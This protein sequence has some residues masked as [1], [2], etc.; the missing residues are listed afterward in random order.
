M[1]RL[2]ALGSIALLPVS[3]FAHLQM[4]CVPA[5]STASASLAPAQTDHAAHSHHARHAAD[6][7]DEGAQDSSPE[8]GSIPQHGQCN[9]C[10][11]Q[12]TTIVTVEPDL[13]FTLLAAHV[14]LL[15]VHAPVLGRAHHLLPFPNPPP[16]A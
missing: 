10:C 8:S 7:T 15:D 14:A 5:P 6:V 3:F 2:A 12:G 4:E 16:V 13:V 1:L 9:L 11:P